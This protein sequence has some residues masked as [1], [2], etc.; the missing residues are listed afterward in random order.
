MVAD[1]SEG[2]MAMTCSRCSSDITVP[3]TTTSHRPDSIPV[4][5]GGLNIDYEV[6]GMVSFTVGTRGGMRAEYERLKALNTQRLA[7]L[8]KKGQLTQSRSVGQFVGGVSLDSEGDIGLSGQYAGASFAS[9]DID[10]AFQ[11][12]VGQLQMRASY[13][14]ANAVIGFRYDIDF[15]SNAN[16]VNFFATAYGTAVRITVPPASI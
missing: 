12:A 8:Q 9:D 7:S 13:L 14:G 15:D 10:M 5:S 1:E 4:T 6:I 11:I 16:V 2:G 3:Q